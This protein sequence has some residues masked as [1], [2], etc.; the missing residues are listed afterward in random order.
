M[1]WIVEE[2]R[3]ERSDAGLAPVS[4]GWFVVNVLEAA[5]FTSEVFGPTCTFEGDDTPPFADVGFS[6]SERETA[7][8]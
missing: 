1:S 7:T 4:D 2:A 6:P 5:W 8:V 3:L